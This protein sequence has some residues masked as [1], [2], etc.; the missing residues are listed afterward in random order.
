MWN[1]RDP[2]IGRVDLWGSIQSLKAMQQIISVLANAGGVGKTTLSI[3]VGYEMARRGHRVALIDLDQQTSMDVFLSLPAQLRAETSVAQA[4]DK[5]FSGEWHLTTPYDDVDRLQVCQG[6][7]ALREV[8]DLLTGRKR[9][10]YC[11]SDRFKAFPL[12]HDLILIDCPATLDM[13]CLNALA[14][15]TGVL[16]PMQMEA[17]ATAGGAGLIEWIIESSIEL[18][19]SPRPPIVGIVP[20]QVDRRLSIHRHYLAEIIGMGPRLNI[21]VFPP[22]RDTTAFKHASAAGLPLPRYQ[23]SHEACRDF[24]TV[25][26]RVE[27]LIR[28]AA[29]AA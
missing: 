20:S 2:Q 17:K 8:S 22:V 26:D 13:L 18:Q 11:L 28:T 19:L 12:P 25:C 5:K 10:E 29:I 4:F 15:S 9:R 14:A 3:H 27:G 6:H 16:I 23:A 7:P 1:P 21:E 24:D